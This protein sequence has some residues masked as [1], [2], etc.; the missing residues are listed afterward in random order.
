MQ[1]SCCRSVALAMVVG[2][3]LAGCGGS[4]EG[5]ELG[6]VSGTVT[7]DGQ[8]LEGAEIQFQP[9]EDRPSRGQTDSS[10]FYR[11][12]FTGNRMGA[13]LGDHTVMITTVRAASGGEGDQPAV[14]ARKELL[15]AR[16]HDKTELVKTVAAGSNTIDFALTS[17]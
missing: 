17:Q 9:A 14:A 6:Q 2:L 7:L 8:P 15:P 12:S 13:V 3:S 10:G 1:L 16:Y 5:P 11:L 4:S